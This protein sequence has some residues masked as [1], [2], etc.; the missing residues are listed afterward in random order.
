MLIYRAVMQL[1]PHCIINTVLIYVLKK[2]FK[3][4]K[5]EHT[6]V[7]CISGKMKQRGTKNEEATGRPVWGEGPWQPMWS[8]CLTSHPRP[9]WASEPALWAGKWG[10]YDSWRPSGK[11]NPTGREKDSR[12][13]REARE[14]FLLWVPNPSARAIPAPPHPTHHHC[15][16]LRSELRPYLF[17]C[18]SGGW[19][20]RFPPLPQPLHHTRAPFLAPNP[21][22]DSIICM[23][24]VFS[25]CITFTL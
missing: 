8:H 9:G 19:R 1:S 14:G 22:R 16:L 5:N 23:R 2:D 15:L 24:T 25:V 3:A 7:K 17:P 21:L 11:P 13:H 20:L 6:R 4:Y 18:L 10:E 12:S